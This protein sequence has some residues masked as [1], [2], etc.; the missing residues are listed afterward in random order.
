[1]D[2][3]KE[4]QKGKKSEAQVKKQTSGKAGIKRKF[5]ETSSK[6]DEAIVVLEDSSS[7]DDELKSMLWDLTSR[8]NKRQKNSSSRGTKD[9]KQNH[10][11]SEDSSKSSQTHLQLP[12][13]EEIQDEDDIVKTNSSTFTSTKKKTESKQNTK[14]KGG[15]TQLNEE[16]K[17]KA[18]EFI[19]PTKNKLTK[20]TTQKQETT[21]PTKNGLS[22]SSGFSFTLSNSKKLKS[23]SELWIEKYKPLTEVTERKT[24]N[25]S[26]FF[27]FN[28]I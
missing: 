7:S 5:E 22:F 6:K 24:I 27:L 16:K 17:P 15:L 28:S 10:L 11:D 19:A 13:T 4:K 12:E 3:A 23:N 21:H 26:N 20:S 14:K 18:A 2:K 8:K 9:L 1:M 25:I